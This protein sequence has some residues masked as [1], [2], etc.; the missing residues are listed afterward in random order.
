MPMRMAVRT[1]SVQLWL[2]DDLLL[3]L[4]KTV[5]SPTNELGWTSPHVHV[6]IS[7][8]RPV[9]HDLPGAV[10]QQDRVRALQIYPDPRYI[11]G[12]LY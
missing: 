8:V 6:Q 11:V 9:T 2:G 3:V 7:T 1:L 12:P 4:L 10:R 5:F